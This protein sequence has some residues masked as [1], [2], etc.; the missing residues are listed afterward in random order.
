MVN[1]NSDVTLLRPRCGFPQVNHSELSFILDRKTWC[2]SQKKYLG[3]E[4]GKMVVKGSENCL[5]TSV[6]PYI[7]L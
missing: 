7:F 1:F 6:Y 4:N 2:F 3:Q 5:V